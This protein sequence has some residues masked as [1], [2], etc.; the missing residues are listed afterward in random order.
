V[1]PDLWRISDAIERIQ[2]LLPDYPEGA[3]MTAFM[4]RIPVDDPSRDLK[5]RAAVASTFVAGLELAKQEVLGLDQPAL[6][7]P[8]T[9]HPFPA[10]AAPDRKRA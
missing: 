6:F 5:S 1:I 9:Y 7:E 8:I 4:P 3:A 10:S 2:R